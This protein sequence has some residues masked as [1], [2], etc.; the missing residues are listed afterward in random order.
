[1]KFK[2]EVTPEDARRIE[3]EAES[4]GLT[5]EEYLVNRIERNLEFL[6]H[7]QEAGRVADEIHAERADAFEALARS[8]AQD[9][10]NLASTEKS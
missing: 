3:A 5:P 9:R 4:Q 10:V 2:V 1:M 6:L 7:K 8:E